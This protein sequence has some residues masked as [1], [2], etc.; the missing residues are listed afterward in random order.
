MQDG[1]TAKEVGGEVEQGV[2]TELLTLYSTT[3][4]IMSESAQFVCASAKVH[5]GND[6]GQ[7]KHDIKETTATK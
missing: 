3:L 2:I 1:A 4:T 6:M 5:A 7:N